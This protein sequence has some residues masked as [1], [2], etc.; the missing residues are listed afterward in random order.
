MRIQRSTSMQVISPK[1]VFNHES[2]SN[3]MAIVNQ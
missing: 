3:K 2:D 1:M